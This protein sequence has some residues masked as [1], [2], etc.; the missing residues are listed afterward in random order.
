MI[1]DIN[2]VPIVL[3][4]M[5]SYNWTW[6]VWYSLFKKYVSNHG[7][8]YFISEEKEPD[9]VDEIIHIKSGKGEW[10][11]RLLRSL[12]Q[13]DSD[14]LFYMQEDFWATK[15][16]VLSN[17]ILDLFYELDME[18]LNI[19]KKVDLPHLMS[20]YIPI[21]D[22]LYKFARHGKFTQ[23]HQFG[24]WKKNVLK[25]NVQP[26]ETPWKNE[27]NGSIRRN[28]NPHKVYLMDYDWYVTSVRRGHILDRG[29]KVLTDN[30]LK[31]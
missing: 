11:E 10:G 21:E 17:D 14:L 5:D 18:T 30:N 25:S 27:V 1:K 16:I 8:I 28:K 23:N 26:N 29:I 15:D 13:I 12:E 7:P 2:E 20:S 6:N 19:C 9:F 24:L 31:L 3:H 22:N 4:S